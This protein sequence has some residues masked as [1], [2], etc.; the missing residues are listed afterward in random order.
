MFRYFIEHLF[1]V[2]DI[3]GTEILMLAL[4]FALAQII[5]CI[6]LWAWFEK[7]NRGF[8]KTLLRTL[9]QSFSSSVIMGFVAYLSLGL[10][11]NVFNINTLIG[12][13]M[14]GLCSGIIGIIALVIVLKLLGSFELKETVSTLHQKFWKMR[15]IVPDTSAEDL[16]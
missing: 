16:K 8:S 5:N 12:I 7:E 1:R 3:P 2:D 11:D 9:F 4:G 13:F 15:P 10:F 14:Q 6:V